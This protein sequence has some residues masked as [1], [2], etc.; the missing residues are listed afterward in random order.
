MTQLK[1]LSSYI[2][3]FAGAAQ[4]AQALMS[5]QEQPMTIKE[6]RFKVNISA[7]IHAKPEGD[8]GLNVWDLTMKDKL[9]LDYKEE[10]GIEVE[11]TMMPSLIAGS[12]EPS[13]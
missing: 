5:T 8:V 9:F 13:T 12:T 7:D 4:A 3:S 2:V 11:C 1:D 10:M 6:Y